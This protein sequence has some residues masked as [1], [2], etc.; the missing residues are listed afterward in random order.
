MQTEAPGAVSMNQGQAWKPIIQPSDPVPAFGANNVKATTPVPRATTP[1]PKPPSWGWNFFNF[2]PR[3]VYVTQTLV[4]VQTSQYMDPN[5]VVTFSVKGCRPSRLPFDLPECEPVRAEPPP[6]AVKS[7]ESGIV[8]M[9]PVHFFQPAPLRTPEPP[10]KEEI[11][12]TV[13]LDEKGK[14]KDVKPAEE[15]E[16][17]KE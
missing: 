10:P 15:N 1:A 8:V 9:A 4:E 6:P 7:P 2:G 14:D 5:T 17:K 11:K 16:K 3:E 13:P 12:E